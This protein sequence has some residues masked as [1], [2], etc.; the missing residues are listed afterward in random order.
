M[1]E[2]AEC[3]S[4]IMEYDKVCPKCGVVLE[5]DHHLD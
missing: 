3:G 1:R 2:C 4:K 5:E